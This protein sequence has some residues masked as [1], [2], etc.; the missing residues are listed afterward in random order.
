M[1]IE[2]ENGKYYLFSKKPDYD[3]FKNSK[4][5]G[6][7]PNVEFFRFETMF[8]YPDNK[9]LLPGETEALKKRQYFTKFDDEKEFYSNVY[10]RNAFLDAK[11]DDFIDR[12]D[13][14]DVGDSLKAV[15]GIDPNIDVPFEGV[16][17]QKFAAFLKKEE[18]ID[19]ADPNKKIR[20]KNLQRRTKHLQI[21]QAS[22]SNTYGQRIK[23]NYG[24][25]QRY[26]ESCERRIRLSC[27][28]SFNAFSYTQ[29]INI[30]LSWNRYIC[31]IV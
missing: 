25:Y 9:P 13:V 24:I 1:A 12:S 31:I 15:C 10:V 11:E 22:L 16:F 5:P 4:K 6:A 14:V 26:K 8:K 7:L 18:I 19:A 27:N 29:R 21:K 23:Q 17:A 20:R 28:K 3:S 2:D 30:R